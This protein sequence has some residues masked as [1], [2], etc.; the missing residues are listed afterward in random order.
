M[1]RTT[2]QTAATMRAAPWAPASQ[3]IA[4][5]WIRC[6]E[7]TMTRACSPTHLFCSSQPAHVH[8]P[9]RRV[10]A[11]V[12]TSVACWH[13]IIGGRTPTRC[14][15]KPKPQLWQPLPRTHG[16]RPARLGKNL[17]LL[18]PHVLQTYGALT[19]LSR[20][21][22]SH[23]PRLVSAG[24]SHRSPYAGSDC[25]RL[26]RH[27]RPHRRRRHRRSY[28]SWHPCTH[29][30]GEASGTLRHGFATRCIEARE[31]GRLTSKMV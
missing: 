9:V 11:L 31:A 6:S 5:H 3:Q 27:L 28:R 13:S 21:A 10:H 30:P 14:T 8:P 19:G 2:G 16:G 1:T 18:A 17:G 4:T 26:R 25:L 12:C 7:Y 24:P 23:H 20:H 15:R 22:S 29:C